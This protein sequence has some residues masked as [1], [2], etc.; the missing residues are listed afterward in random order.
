LGHTLKSSSLAAYESHLCSYLTF[1]KSHNFPIQPTAGTLSFYVI[2]M[3]HHIEPTSIGAY[4]SG[5]CNTLELYFLEVHKV[6]SSTIV[7]W[8]LAGMKKLKG[9][10]ST[11][12]KHVLSQEDLLFIIGHLPSPPSHDDYL[13][14]AMILT[15]F[16]GLLCLGELT[17]PDSIHK[18]SSKKLTLHH[19]LSIEK[20]RFSFTLPF[21]KA[22]HFYASNTVMIEALLLLPISPLFHLHHY[23]HSHNCLFALLPMLWVTSNGTPPTYSWFVCCLQCHQPLLTI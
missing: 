9:L 7:T 6:C 18:W 16:F 20:S 17:F 12:R 2:Y 15:G 5:I 21:H 11:M 3:S 1:C 14:T 10:Q 4:L 22:D 13:F 8:S 23:L 19:T